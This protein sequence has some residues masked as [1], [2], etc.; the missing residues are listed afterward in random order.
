MMLEEKRDLPPE[1]RRSRQGHHF[2]NCVDLI[3]ENRLQGE[4]T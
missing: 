2:G 4:T 1:I 3:D